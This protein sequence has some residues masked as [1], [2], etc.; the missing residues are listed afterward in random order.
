MIGRPKLPAK[1]R[2]SKMIC[3]R[4][5][6]DELKRLEQQAQKAKLSVVDFI[7]QNLGLRGDK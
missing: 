7:R 2:S 5:T 6:P 1:A 3:L 4:L